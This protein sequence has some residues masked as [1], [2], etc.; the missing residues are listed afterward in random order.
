M[1]S[2]SVA[3]AVKWKSV[4]ETRNVRVYSHLL[5]CRMLWIVPVM[6]LSVVGGEELAWK[7]MCQ[8]SLSRKPVR[9]KWVDRINKYFKVVKKKKCKNE[10]LVKNYLF[11]WI[12]SSISSL[13]QHLLHNMLHAWNRDFTNPDRRFP[14]FFFSHIW[15]R[16][17]LSEKSSFSTYNVFS[18]SFLERNFIL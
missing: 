15:M 12:I 2:I 1:C 14:H 3:L 8:N 5:Y 16:P 9:S 18:F 7:P 13:T 4:L 10:N 6:A 11:T 17:F